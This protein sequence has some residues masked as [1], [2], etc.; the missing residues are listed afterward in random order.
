M[1]EWLDRYEGWLKDMLSHVHTADYEMLVE[2]VDEREDLTSELA[3]LSREVSF[4]TS[5][6]LRRD[7]L[8]HKSDILLRR[9]IELRQEASDFMERRSQFKQMKS[10]YESAY[11]AESIL[12]DKRN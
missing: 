4:T 9:M 11:A 3:E 1:D 7:D 12:F 5:Q 10:M 8:L 6:S 2:F